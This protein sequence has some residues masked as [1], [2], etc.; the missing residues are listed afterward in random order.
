MTY[1]IRIASMLAALAIGV[2]AAP[3]QATFAFANLGD[4]AVFNF[5]GDGTSPD[6][7][8][9]S[10]STLNF[11]GSDMV[12][13]GT[14]ELEAVVGATPTILGSI[15]LTTGA[16]NNG[17]WFE[18]DYTR[19]PG[20]SMPVA[21]AGSETGTLQFAITSTLEASV[22]TSGTMQDFT[23]AGELEVT[24][25]SGF[26]NSPSIGTFRLEGS[27]S[28]LLSGFGMSLQIEVE[29]AESMIVSEPALLAVIGAGLVAV[30]A[31]QMRR[32]RR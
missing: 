18:V 29:G 13:F 9:A 8:L 1:S 30:G 32:R 19:F 5:G 22:N 7:A 24:D 25:L 4:I 15:D 10:G 27:T 14:R 11:D 26:Y 12:P 6:N 3:A 16:G 21:P 20:M 28:T 2:A 31:A 17:V 23:F